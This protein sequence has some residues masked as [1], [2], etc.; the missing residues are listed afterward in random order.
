MTGSLLE[1]PCIALA[2]AGTVH[3]HGNPRVIAELAEFGADLAEGLFGLLDVCRKAAFSAWAGLAVI[4]PLE[5]LAL[6]PLPADNAGEALSCVLGVAL[7]PLVGGQLRTGNTDESCGLSEVS[8]GESFLS[9]IEVGSGIDRAD[10]TDPAK[11]TVGGA[12]PLL[13]HSMRLA[14]MLRSP[15]FRPPTRMGSFGL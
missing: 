7:P 2:L 4:V 14:E 10:G 6:N 1:V 13:A 3:R 11:I 9:L 12:G 8:L 5:V 15:G